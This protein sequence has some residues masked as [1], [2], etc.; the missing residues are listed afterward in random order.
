[1]RTSVLVLAILA[2][3][4]GG[5]GI[6]A[7]LLFGATLLR[8]SAGAAGQGAASGALLALLGLV[9]GIGGTALVPRRARLAGVLCLI[10][11]VVGTLGTFAFGLGALL[12]VIGGGMAFFVRSD[13]G[14][15][16]PSA[17]L[18][19]PAGR[20]SWHR[21]KVPR[22]QRRVWIPSAAAMVLA[23][24][25]LVGSSLAQSAE[26]R[27][28]HALLEGLQKADDVALASVLAPRLRAGN[29]ARDADIA[30][31]LALG[32]SEISFVNADWLRRL[33]PVTGTRIG[34]ERL[35]LTTTDK[36]ESTAT[37]H[38]RGLFVPTN[39]NPLLQL[40]VQGMR[41][42]FDANIA[43]ARADG[44]WYAAGSPS[45]GAP[46]SAGRPAT[47]TLAVRS[48]APS[49]F[50]LRHLALGTYAV[51]PSAAVLSQGWRLTLRD[52]TINL[53]ESVVFDFELTVGPADGPWAAR[54][55]RLELRSGQWLDVRAAGSTFYDGGRGPGAVVPVALAFPPGL[56]GE[57]PY[58]IRVCGN[59]GFCWPPLPGPP[60][61]ER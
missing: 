20:H 41:Q 39:E 19:T 10:A 60:L 38:V 33:G 53:D 61:G 30:L 7:A 55:S 42:R 46:S 48:A 1:M 2:D 51:E 8:L 23:I 9:V 34:F 32:A 40:L 16:A 28:V 25:L 47:P 43:V 4:F 11:A 12:Y 5:L 6:I 27:P 50:V 13:S 22:V 36:T 29:A 3:V 21:P 56:A 15:A 18:P 58:V 59:L 57:Q 45:A 44:E 49:P 35:T 14:V 52:V 26:Q 24:G 31:G 54:E 17:P 37:V